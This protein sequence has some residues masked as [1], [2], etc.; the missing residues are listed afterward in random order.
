M[1][2]LLSRRAVALLATIVS[3]GALFALFDDA[4]ASRPAPNAE[5]AE[6]ASQ[7]VDHYHRHQGEVTLGALIDLQ[8]ARRATRSA[9]DKAL[10][11]TSRLEPD[12]WH[13]QLGAFGTADAAERA[14]DA[15]LQTAAL[16]LPVTVQHEGTLYRVRSA[17][18]SRSQADAFC[19][20]VSQGGRACFVRRT[21]G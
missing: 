3:A 4:R 12:G 14:R 17:S 11:P 5:V 8:R 15:V 18:A 10:A 2:R 13:G 7:H 6:A 19:Q 1:L 21:D 20:L 9:E 16:P